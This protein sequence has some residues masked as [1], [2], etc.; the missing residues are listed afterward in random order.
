MMIFII[1]T[2][3]MYVHVVMEQVYKETRKLDWYSNVHVVS[4][5]GGKEIL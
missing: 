3:R 5:V 1:H 2:N 4:E